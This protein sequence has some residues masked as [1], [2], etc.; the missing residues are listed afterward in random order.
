[1][2]DTIL[3]IVSSLKDGL[4][5]YKDAQKDT[6]KIFIE[7]ALADFEKVHLNYLDTF[8]NYLNILNSNTEPLNINH[9]LFK[10]METDSIF[11]EHLRGN[12]F[13]F[14][15]Y[16]DDNFKIFAFSI[17]DYLMYSNSA[18]RFNN[19]IDHREYIMSS[20]ACRYEAYHGLKSIFSYD[21][22]SEEQKRK[23]A[24]DQFN[25]ILKR[26]QNKHRKVINNYNSLKKE[27]MK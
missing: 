18:F 12:I 1:M 9:C 25:G 20:N 6:F 2:I 26:L 5:F 24:I 4:K 8:S 27:F 22:S 10:M 13:S 23:D 3:K 11:S 7:P 17:Y 21:N 14:C 19:T 16:S 15:D